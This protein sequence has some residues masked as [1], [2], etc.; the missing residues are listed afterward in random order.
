MG[1]KRPDSE[2]FACAFLFWEKEVFWEKQVFW[3]KCFGRSVVGEN[4]SLS[5][6]KST[7]M[8]QRE[9]KIRI[10]CLAVCLRR[11]WIR[12]LQQQVSSIDVDENGTSASIMEW[13]CVRESL[14]EDILRL[15]TEMRVLSRKKQE[16]TMESAGAR[17][18]MEMR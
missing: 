18:R 1:A 11:N 5:K 9:D 8:T 16:L 7:S 15:K 13:N 2:H 12:H 17:L 10:I 6:T 3:E 14:E 4:T